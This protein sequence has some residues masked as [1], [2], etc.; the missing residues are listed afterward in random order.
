MADTIIVGVGNPYRG[1][2]KA[3]WE[4][5]DR[6]EKKVHETI[7][8]AK[9]GG[10]FCDLLEIFSAYKNVYLIDACQGK[11]LG[12]RYIRIDAK[13]SKIPLDANQASTHGLG[14]AQAIALAENLKILPEK[15]IIYALPGKRYSISDNISSHMDK[16]ID[17]V[18]EQL[19][20]EKEISC[21]NLI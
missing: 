3:G 14:V 16:M 10:D 15:L 6:L 18:I 1:D 20:K 4:V 7:H 9:K 19:L 17:E 11:N 13:Q 8:L 21:M 2:D 5:I 12:D